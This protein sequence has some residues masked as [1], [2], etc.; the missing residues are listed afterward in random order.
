M[1]NAARIL[2]VEDDSDICQLITDALLKEGYKVNAVHNGLAAVDEFAANRYDL[3]ILDI[4][5]PGID[6]FEV[7]RRIREKEKIPILL[8]SAKD[9][10][11]D[12]IL[13]LGGGADD[14]LTK[15]FLL[16]E[17]LARVRAQLRRCFYYHPEVVRTS[18]PVISY[19]KLKMNLNTYQVEV[20][21]ETKVL[22]SKEFDILRLLISSPRRVF[23]KSQ[24]F[25]NIW[26]EPFSSEVDENTIMVHI[27][28]LRIKI[29]A[30]PSHPEYIQTVWG[31][32]YRLGGEE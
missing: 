15:P 18:D 7:L 17:L 14:Y 10:E 6:G 16:G 22:T 25:E 12:K 21:G 11:V 29:E 27:R 26:N 13:G 30:D 20:D 4:M 5:L 32:G 8:L 24:I 3:M 19:K 1:E 31:I 9:E 28:R 2:I 23:T